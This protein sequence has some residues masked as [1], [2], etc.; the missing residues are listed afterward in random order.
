MLC[1]PYNGSYVTN[2][3]PRCE[4]A[5]PDDESGLVPSKLMI[6]KTK[7]LFEKFYYN[8]ILYYIFYT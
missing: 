3:H 8:L 5:L 7:I 2:G 4:Y 1:L 6:G